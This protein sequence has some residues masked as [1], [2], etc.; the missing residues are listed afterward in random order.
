MLEPAGPGRSPEQTN[1]ETHVPKGW[2]TAV[3]Q[4]AHADHCGHAVTTGLLTQRREHANG[5]EQ[6]AETL[7]MTGIAASRVDW[8]W[9]T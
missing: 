1:L 7:Q 9:N 5:G 3:A 4:S 8:F 6:D 2:G